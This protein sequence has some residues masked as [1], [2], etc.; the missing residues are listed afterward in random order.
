MDKNESLEKR[1][2]DLLRSRNLK[3]AVAESC[4]G[5]LICHRITNIPGSSDYFNFGVVVYSNAAKMQILDVPK[6]VL[7]SFGAVS[8]ETARVMAEN[9]RK[10][11][12]CDVGL[13]VTGIAGPGG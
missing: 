5:G 6:L 1:V 7:E 3:M 11:S 8:A 12:G 13:A 4:T 9:V 2:G 10:L